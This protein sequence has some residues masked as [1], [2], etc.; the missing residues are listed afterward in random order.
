[1]SALINYQLYNM[2][3][4]SLL[5]D[6][7]I[8]AENCLANLTILVTGATSD[9]GRSVGEA[10]AQ[11]GATVILLDRKQ[12]EI[13]IVYDR[14]VENRSP[15]PVIVEFDILKAGATEFDALRQSLF[16]AYP[17]ID[18]LV[19]CAQWG[20]PL[21]PLVNSDL[22][23]WPRILDQQ[24]IKPVQLTQALIPSLSQSKSA[25]IV[26]TT[27]DVGRV[28]RAYWGA[29]G[30]GIAALENTAVCIAS[31][32]E[33]SKIRVNTIDPGKLKTAFRK[34]FYPGENPASLIESSDPR[35]ISTYLYLLSPA[36]SDVSAQQ[37]SI[38]PG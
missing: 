6:G 27:M 9:L 31:E 22:G 15:E 1:M 5:P 34:Q 11:A 13:E 28:A 14:I 4:I 20:A 7:F 18:G 33:D 8:P 35:V 32:L 10:A 21:A 16:E 26:F 29:V 24:L 3:R 37:F 36:S 19:H 12:R 23:L 38:T 2:T 17:S 25:S 30:A